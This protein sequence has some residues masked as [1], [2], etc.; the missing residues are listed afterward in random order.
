MNYTARLRT[1]G[2]LFQAVIP[3]TYHYSRPQMQAPFLVWAED[4]LD[5]FFADNKTSE[6]TILGTAD[7]Y[8]Q[9]EYDPAIDKLMD[10]FEGYGFSW[11]VNS[12]QYEEATE[13]IHYEFSWG[14]SAGGHSEN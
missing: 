13:L 5:R 6:F 10:L 2:K 12:I 9:Q 7:Y 11:S 8:T 14:V 3:H 4:G 1:I